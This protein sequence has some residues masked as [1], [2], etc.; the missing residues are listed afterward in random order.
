MLIDFICIPFGAN[1]LFDGR[2]C[3]GLSNWIRCHHP[4]GFAAVCDGLE[5][6]PC[7]RTIGIAIRRA[8]RLHD[9]A[10]DKLQDQASTVGAWHG[11]P[12]KRDLHFFKEL[13][14]LLLRN[15]NDQPDE[16]G[17]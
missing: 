17:Q 16:A 2:R 12:S 11:S 9:R 15:T 1:G 8:P 13:L 7:A 3:K 6:S 5:D 14:P 10:G 4:A